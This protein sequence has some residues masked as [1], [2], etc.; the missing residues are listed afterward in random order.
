[1]AIFDLNTGKGLRAVREFRGLSRE[2]LA[3]AAEIDPYTVR[4]W[5]RKQFWK[6]QGWAMERI[7]KALGLGHSYSS[8]RARDI[9]GFNS[10]SA[11]L[12]Q[13]AEDPLVDLRARQ[14]AAPR[15]STARVRCGAKTRKGHPCKAKSLPG[16]RRCKF[17]GGMSTGPRTPEGKAAVGAAA[18]ARWARWRAEKAQANM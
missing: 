5:E 8:T 4:Y 11:R 16:K 13:M 3:K 7:V 17:H 1:M 15:P 9:K 6:K 18:K 12:D 14:T 2:A 10:M